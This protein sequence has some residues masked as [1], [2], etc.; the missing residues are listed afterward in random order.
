MVLGVV[1]FVLW[2][3]FMI[4]ARRGNA[5]LGLR[6]AAA[7]STVLAGKRVR[8]VRGKKTDLPA[9]EGRPV[10]GVYAGCVEGC[11]SL[12]V[13]GQ[14]L[15]FAYKSATVVCSHAPGVV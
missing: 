15:D 5:V 13:N 7:A 1:S 14:C 8:A 10:P 12:L 9:S 11:I 3:A 2:G 6:V 4:L